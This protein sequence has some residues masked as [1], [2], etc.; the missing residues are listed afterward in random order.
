ME[1]DDSLSGIAGD[2][3]TFCPMAWI[4]LGPP[5]FRDF[6]SE[7]DSFLVFFPRPSV[8]NAL[9]QI[10][11]TL[12]RGDW[13]VFNQRVFAPGHKPFHRLSSWNP[14]FRLCDM[15]TGLTGSLLSEGIGSKNWTN[16]SFFS[17]F[18]AHDL[19]WDGKWYVRLNRPHGFEK[20]IHRSRARSRRTPG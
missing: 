8:P 17:S 20:F 13:L 19:L 3:Y 9:S 1:G 18:R 5:Q 15:Q 14:R 6:S 2:L 16:P 7:L 10:D 4:I 12:N 11:P